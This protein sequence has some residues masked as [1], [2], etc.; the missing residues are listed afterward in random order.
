MPLA[1]ALLVGLEPAALLVEPVATPVELPA[2]VD[3][4][5]VAALE[6]SALLVTVAL[7]ESAALDEVA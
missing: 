1:E 7:V 5:P 3:A 2:E 6:T 4:A